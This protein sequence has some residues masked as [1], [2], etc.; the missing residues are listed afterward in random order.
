MCTSQL[1][2]E[3]MWNAMRTTLRLL[4]TSARARRN[5]PSFPP[6]VQA[7]SG[8]LPDGRKRN[9]LLKSGNQ[10]KI[11]TKTTTNPFVVPLS[12]HFSNVCTVFITNIRLY[13]IG[14]GCGSTLGVVQPY[15]H[16]N[17]PVTY[18]GLYRVLERLLEVGMWVFRSCGFGKNT[19][20]NLGWICLP[21]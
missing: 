9:D 19:R 7:A 1:L 14:G 12:L 16:Q 4:P 20:E 10:Q 17:L 15:N 13:F 6:P 11:S 3:E 21:R 5:K 8:L 18:P 2:L